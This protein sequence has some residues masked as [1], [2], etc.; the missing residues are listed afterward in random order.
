MVAS[1][2]VI[3]GQKIP[4]GAVVQ[5]LYASAINPFTGQALRVQILGVR[6]IG[7][8]GTEQYT[9]VDVRAPYAILGFTVRQEE[10]K[11]I[12]A[13]VSIEIHD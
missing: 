1:T 9:G 5:A 8:P 4:Q 12:V 3:Q 6:K 13:I 7:L 2:P 11:N 10:L